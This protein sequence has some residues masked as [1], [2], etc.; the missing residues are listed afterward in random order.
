MNSF[1]IASIVLGTVLCVSTQDP[2][3]QTQTPPF[4]LIITSNESVPPNAQVILEITVK[5]NTDHEIGLLET[6]PEC[7]YPAEVRRQGGAMATETAHR[8]Q[9]QTCGQGGLVTHIY[10][11]PHESKVVDKIAVSSLFDMNPVGQYSI[12]IMRKVPEEL[13]VG[14]VKSNVLTVSRT[15]N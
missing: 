3:A 14:T 4:S 9:L 5:N 8:R 11:K 15:A 13:G 10:F 1:V 2:K 12:Q 6:N 7:D